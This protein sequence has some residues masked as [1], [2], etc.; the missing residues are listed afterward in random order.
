MSE[1][2]RNQEAAANVENNEAVEATETVES[3]VPAA[4]NEEEVTSQEG[5]EIIS[6]KKAIP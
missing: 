3:A 4:G 1:E 5:L 6:L 2:T